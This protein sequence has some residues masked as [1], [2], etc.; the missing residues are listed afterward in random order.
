MFEAS[1]LICDPFLLGDCILVAPSWWVGKLARGL[2]NQL[3]LLICSV[4]GTRSLD[5]QGQPMQSDV[6]PYCEGAASASSL[7]L[8][9]SMVSCGPMRSHGEYS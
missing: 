9:Q 1:A 5:D 8:P 3:G 7:K 2:Q 4:V 6:N